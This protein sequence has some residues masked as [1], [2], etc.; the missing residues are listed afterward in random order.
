MQK[1]WIKNVKWDEKLT[2]SL[3]TEFLSWYQGLIALKSI[4]IPRRLGYIPDAKYEIFGFCDAS[5]MEYA[6]CVYLKNIKN[7]KTE[8]R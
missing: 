3:S 6:A 7:N 5:Q 2:I 8:I 1:F 4:R